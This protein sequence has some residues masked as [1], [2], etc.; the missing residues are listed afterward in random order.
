MSNVLC[1]DMKLQLI[2]TYDVRIIKENLLDRSV[3][4][5]THVGTQVSSPPFLTRQGLFPSFL[6]HERAIWRA[7]VLVLV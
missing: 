4:L 7:Y 3:R 1:N 6:A 5:I 2:Q